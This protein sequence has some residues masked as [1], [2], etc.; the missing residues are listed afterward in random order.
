MKKSV[1]TLSMVTL[2][3][4]FPLVLQAQ[5]QSLMLGPADFAPYLDDH[6][7]VRRSY[8]LYSTSGASNQYFYAP[9][10]LPNGVR[11]KRVVLF[12]HDSG[13]GFLLLNVIR[14]NKYNFYSEDVI[15]FTLTSGT[16]GNSTLT[17]GANWAYNLINNNGYT[18][19]LM[20]HFN[21][22]GSEYKFYGAKVIYQ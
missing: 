11:L 8:E 18:Y 7:Y 10:H 6:D 9:I 12:F 17:A 16:P 3:F 2:F 13:S 1:L 21:E 20:I 4:L 19:T 14:D 22:S 5:E 15:G